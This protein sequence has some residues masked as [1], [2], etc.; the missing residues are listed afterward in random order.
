[1]FGSYRINE[2]KKGAVPRL[3]LFFSK[4]ARLNFYSCSIRLLDNSEVKKL[5]D[6]EIDIM[7][8]KWNLRK[9]MDLVSNKGEKLICDILLDQRIFVGVGNIIKNEALYISH[10]HPL[11]IV[12][13][14]PRRKMKEIAIAAHEFSKVFYEAVK[15]GDSVRS[16]LT[17]YGKRECPESGERVTIQK[18]GNLNRISYFCSSSQKL[19]I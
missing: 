1:M 6:V 11:S 9:V 8:Q 18:T 12:E 4:E 3:A 2:E 7:S 14:I 15:K 19:F 10:V 5:C 17:I 16:H 13:K